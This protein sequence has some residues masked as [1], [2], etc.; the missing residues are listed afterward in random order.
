MRNTTYTRIHVPYEEFRLWS[1]SRW[2]FRE[3]CVYVFKEALA[4]LFVV[5][6]VCVSL[7]VIWLWMVL[8]FSM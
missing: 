8:I 2:T 3:K 4:G 6:S 5:T 7:A 1:W